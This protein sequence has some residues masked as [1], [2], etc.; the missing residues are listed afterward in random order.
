MSKNYIKLIDNL[1]TIATTNSKS[2]KLNDIFTSS[3][4]GYNFKINEFWEGEKIEH[5]E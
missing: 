1:T 2:T 3:I 5:L 4:T